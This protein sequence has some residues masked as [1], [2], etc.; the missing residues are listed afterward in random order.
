MWWKKSWDL[1]FFFPPVIS[2]SEVCISGLGLFYYYFVF[3]FIILVSFILDH[4]ISFI[5]LDFDVNELFLKNSMMASAFSWFPTFCLNQKMFPGPSP[6]VGESYINLIS[7]AVLK[8]LLE[9]C[10]DRLFSWA[11]QLQHSVLI[12]HN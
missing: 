10:Q 11:V 8:E 3:T 7:R 9:L 12:C 1:R 2:E 6:L 4:L 5:I